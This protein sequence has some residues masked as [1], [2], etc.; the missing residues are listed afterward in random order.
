MTL[1]EQYIDD[2]TTGKRVAGRLERLSVERSLRLWKD[3]RYFFDKEEVDRV[4][5]IIGMFRHT[6]GKWDGQPFDILPWQAFFW[7]HIFGLKERNTGK[8]LTRVVLLCMAKKGGKSEVGAVTGNVMTFFDGENAA[9]NYSAANKYDQATIS[10]NAAKKMI[11]KA[12]HEWPSFGSNVKIYDSITT[13]SI[14]DLASD[15]FFKPIA[16]DSKTLDGVMPHFSLIDEYHEAVDSSIPDNLISG[17]VSR[18]QPLLM[19]VTTRGFNPQGPLG[20]LEKT[21]TQ[22]LEGKIQDDSVFPLIFS[23]DQEDV[24]KLNDLWGAPFD[25]LPFELISKPNPGIGTA[26][27]I[28]GIRKVYNKAVTEGT[29][30]QTSTLTKNFNVWVRQKD[31]WIPDNVWMGNSDH[32]PDEL[33]LGKQ[34][35]GAYDLSRKRDITAVAHLFP[36]CDDFDCWAIRMSYYCPEES[37]EQRSRKDKVPYMDWANE[38]LLTLTPGN[39]IDYEY[40]ENE[41]MECC[42]KWDV[43]NY[44]YDPMFATALSTSLHMQG[45]EVTKYRQTVMNFNEPIEWLDAALAQKQFAHSGDPVLRW[46]AGNV[47]LRFNSTGL[48]MFDKDKAMD[49]IDG[50]VALAM[51]VGGYLEYLRNNEPTGTAA[52]MLGWI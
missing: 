48:K 36:P 12:S 52:D 38:G 27:S 9:E 47:V 5:R 10:W 51:A 41:I 30:S 19:F 43:V 24:Q 11:R 17:A 15:S 46:M 39:I 45:I 23:L 21:H 50:M 34:C 8:R 13:R 16:A 31:V 18:E 20:Q 6:K 7:A 4:L 14:R 29:A 32:V 3:D 25:E 44:Q 22:I 28:D 49:R 40:V 33:L 2:V 37:A 35:F 1:Y 26:P 42:G